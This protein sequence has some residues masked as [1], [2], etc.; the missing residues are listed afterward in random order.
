VTIAGERWLADV[1]FGD[2]F[3]AP[4]R[5]DADREQLDPAGTFRIAATGEAFVLQRCSHDAWEPQYRFTLA[6]RRLAEF[7]AMCDYHQ[8]SP[9]SSFTQKAVCSM[10]TPTGRITLSGFRMIDTANGQRTERELAGEREWR[11][12]LGEGFGIELPS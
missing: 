6:A 3:V 10:A 4:L 2:S 9:L 5:F 8:T 11:T 7:A 1:G 12:V